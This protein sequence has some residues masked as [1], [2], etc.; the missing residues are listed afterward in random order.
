MWVF[1]HQKQRNMSDLSPFHQEILSFL[2]SSAETREKEEGFDLSADPDLQQLHGSLDV[3]LCKASGPLPLDEILKRYQYV[4]GERGPI[5]LE[6]QWMSSFSEQEFAEL[7]LSAYF[8]KIYR[9]LPRL[10]HRDNPSRSH[11]KKNFTQLSDLKRLSIDRALF[12]LYEKAVLPAGMKVSIFSW[13]IPDGL[14]DWVAAQE[15]AFLL[16]EKLPQLEIQLIFVTPRKLPSVGE[17]AVREIYYDKEPSLA[18]VSAD[19]LQMLRQSDLILQIPTFFPHSEELWE[20]VQAISSNRSLPIIETIG[21]YGFLESSW[22]HPKSRNRSMGLH[23]LE[24]G[25]FIHKSSHCTFAEIEQKN[26]LNWLF[27]TETPGPYE[28]ET[29]QKSRCFYMGYLATPLGGAIYLHS[30]LKLHER[31]ER[32]IDLCCPDLGWLIR[33]IEERRKEGLSPLEDS[34]GIRDISILAFDQSHVMQLNES[35][36]TVRILCPGSISLSDMR[37]LFHLSGDW[38]GVRGNQSF[39]EAVSAGKAFFYDGRDHAR[40]FMKDLIALAEN[41]LAG[42]KSALQAFRML[43]QAFLWNLPEELGDWVDESHFQRN[44]RLPWLHIAH[45]LGNCLLDPDA[46]V[47]YKKFC[48]IA[49]E[50]H[51]FNDFLWHLVLRALTHHLHPDLRESETRQLNLYLAGKLS[52]SSFIKNLRVRMMQ[53]TL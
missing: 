2:K 10:Y 31:D 35:G 51:S 38:V 41:R 52:F 28:I 13:I 9:G 8:P 36:K 15:A 27:G 6:R 46:I 49:A 45:E 1:S 50:E 24:K 53:I 47:G 34:Y 20:T 42:H 40:Y 12:S 44:E 18:C 26:L 39:T 48:L 17:F 29:Y 22:F 21:E 14:G 37:K 33:W 4:F 23:V 16:R 30:L 11:I 7:G 5:H 19:D 43:G 32:D 25:I 3:A